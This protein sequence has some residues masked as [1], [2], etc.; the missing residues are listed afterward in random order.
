[1]SATTEVALYN[2]A[3]SLA[4][5]SVT[6]V[7]TTETSREAQLCKLWFDDVRDAVLSA[8]QWQSTKKV[9][10]L[11]QDEE[12]DTADD[13]Q[14][15][16]PFPGYL[17]SYVL[18]SDM[19]YPWRLATWDRFELGVDQNNARRLFTDREDAVLIYARQE[20][21]ITTWEHALKMAIV[22]ALSAYICGP[23]TGKIQRMQLLLSWANDAIQQARLA[24]GNTQ[25]LQVETDPS[26]IQARGA[27]LTLGQTRYFYPYGQL[28]TLTGAP[29][30]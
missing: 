25:D 24:T 11:E 6:V 28:L 27:N 20:T 30:T 13:W 19:L 2:L 9:L 4:G 18:P 17:Y 3:L 10:M 7:S 21:T 1:M 29:V 26:W 15:Y 14:N 12:R 16:D 23:L 22:H 8:A 5:S